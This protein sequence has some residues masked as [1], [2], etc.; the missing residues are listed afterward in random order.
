ML[1]V[2]KS[3]VGAQLSN[4]T[5]VMKS[6]IYEIKVFGNLTYFVVSVS[7]ALRYPSSL[8]SFLEFRCFKN[9]RRIIINYLINLLIYSLQ[10]N[11]N[12]ES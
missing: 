8:H 1:P 11:Y 6:D 3:L 12:A 4:N 9:L 2:W 10:N 7:A 5:K